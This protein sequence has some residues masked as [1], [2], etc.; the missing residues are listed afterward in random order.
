MVGAPRQG[1]T[2]GATSATQ[3]GFAPG[4]ASQRRLVVPVRVKAGSK[5]WETH[6]MLDGGATTTVV[7]QRLTKRLALQRRKQRTHLHTVEGVSHKVWDKVSLEIQSLDRG[8]KIETDALVGECLTTEEDKPARDWEVKD[9]EH[10][11]GVHFCDVGHE[12]IDVIIPV[13]HGWTWMGGE[14]RRSMGCSLLA[15]K[16]A[17]GWTL[18]GSMKGNHVVQ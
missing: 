15:L 2:F 1:T 12:D 18:A 13:E 3:L 5:E 9:M 17:W 11:E 16:T 7:S 8:V 4:E 10:M 14:T 6:A